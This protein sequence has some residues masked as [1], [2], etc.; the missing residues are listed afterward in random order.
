MSIT[1]GTRGLQLGSKFRYLESSIQDFD[2]GIVL[3]LLRDG[4]YDGSVAYVI[5]DAVP[6]DDCRIVY[7]NFRSIIA[8]KGSQR[9][10]DDII[11]ANQI[12]STQFQK[13]RRVHLQ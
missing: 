7:S 5:R 1:D 8:E 12:G 4:H 3:G 9:E 2:V 11:K 6:T 10:L 13:S